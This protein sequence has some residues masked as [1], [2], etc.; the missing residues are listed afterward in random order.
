VSVA[1]VLPGLHRLADLT[2]L[3]AALGHEPR[4]EEA[5]A[6]YWIPASRVAVVG[7]SGGFLWYGAEG[8]EP[9]RTALS[10]ARRLRKHGRVAGVLA[11]D[12]HHRHLAAAVA[13]ADLPVLG[14]SLTAPDRLA[15]ACLER[16]S[17]PA[18]AT[19]GPLA[20]AARAA[21][22]LEGEAVGKRFFLA[23]RATLDRM[24][25]ALSRPRAEP[26]RHALAL[27]Q[28]TRVLFLYFVQSKGWLDGRPD[29]LARAVDACLAARRHLHQDLLEPLFFGT[30]NRPPAIRSRVPKRFGQVPFLNGGL[31]EPH[32]LER[33]REH[34]LPNALWRDAFDSLFERFHFTAE[35]RSQPDL[36][37]PDMLGRV[38]EGVMEP[39]ARRRSGTFYTPAPL[40]QG[41][42]RAG[43]TA[44][45]APQAGC[46]EERAEQMLEERHPLV[47]RALRRITIL[48]PAVGS[49]AFLLG[50]LD[51]LAAPGRP[52]ARR[53]VLRRSLYGVDL[54]AAAVRLSELRLWLAVIAEDRAGAPDE[55]E[56]LPNLDA[57]VRQGDSLLD[58]LGGPL[59]VR[60]SPLTRRLARVRGRLVDATGPVK[61]AL[62]R[63]L[64]QTESLILGSS[65]EAAEEVLGRRIAACLAE[66]RGSTLFGAR[67]G[68]DAP[69]R[70][71]LSR[72]RAERHALRLTRR[73][74]A[75]RGELPWFHYET[76]FAD[77]IARGGFDLI[78][79]NPP[80]VRGEQL[81]PEQR[82]RLAA[83]YRWW[84]PG[85]RGFAHRPDLSL[86]FVERGLELARPG[87]VLAML[88]PVKLA[89]AG[90]AARARHALATEAML[91]VVADLEHHRSAF[92]ATTYPMAL[93]VSRR[94][95]EEGHL[96]RGV[97]SVREPAVMPQ[98]SLGGG[99]PWVLTAEV[100]GADPLAG[101]SQAPR[102]RERFTPHLGVKTGANDLF[103]DPPSSVEPELVRAAVRGR[104]VRPFAPARGPRLLW[105]CDEAGRPLAELPAGALEHLAPAVGRLRA[106]ADYDG[107]P[108]WTLFRT[109]PASAAHR[110]VWADLSRRLT[111][112]ALTGASAERQIPLNSCYV[113]VAPDAETAQRLAAWLN[114]TW[115]RAAA[116]VG[117]TVAAGGYAR[118]SAAPVGRLP[119]PDAALADATLG[120]I[121]R[122]G[123][124]GTAVQADLDDVTAR[125]LALTAAA[126]RTLAAVP[127]VAD[128]RR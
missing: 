12:G 19:G 70:R 111:A 94:R 59:P 8:P 74:L 116:R 127:G 49:G 14:C 18:T 109:G 107:G 25:S 43:L 13:F 110:V 6:G 39:A 61:R 35:E 58:R 4:F 75:Q 41:L 21:E 32:P 71:E 9:E 100:P 86:A 106:R 97:L 63:E 55:V 125:H 1:S 3:V 80:W 66:A 76:Q 28:L 46:S 24:S 102:L 40:V 88:V 52:G 45:L 11:I 90:Y 126:R 48:D 27:L 98:R 79:G 84:R 50:A 82:A 16:L 31:F 78:V 121:A 22:A 115:I 114:C 5:P 51:L 62:V 128:D 72:L 95:P 89:T 38:F 57:L 15:L 77:V 47:Q 30:L 67:R 123:A 42:L 103:L 101:A 7:G 60:H 69:L 119:L 104:D 96:V 26:E 33:G 73:R 120:E 56:P 99:G 112:L 36:I 93:V 53:R 34:V 113:A 68:L 85:G 117:A 81:A 29:F 105:P 37:A 118:F 87:G 65:L 2:R 10:L 64:R 92:D 108:P 122:A 20:Y 124:A 54:N 23:F 83:R 91:H 44:W 17:G